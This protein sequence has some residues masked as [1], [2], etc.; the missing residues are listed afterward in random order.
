MIGDKNA[1]PS[2]GGKGFRYHLLWTF[3]NVMNFNKNLK[4]CDVSSKSVFIKYA[5]ICYFCLLFAKINH[6]IFNPPS[7]TK[8]RYLV[9]TY[10]CLWKERVNS[11][12]QKTL[13]ADKQILELKRQLAAKEGKNERFVLT[14]VSVCVLTGGIT[15]NS[16]TPTRRRRLDTNW[17]M[18]TTCTAKL[19]FGQLGWGGLK[20]LGK[21]LLSIGLRTASSLN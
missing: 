1:E 12:I 13:E 15:V 21:L 10:Q 18:Q 19:F 6:D 9:E 8:Q 17:R 20:A 5:F 2:K 14:S 16:L 11:D 7:I 4:W 3:R